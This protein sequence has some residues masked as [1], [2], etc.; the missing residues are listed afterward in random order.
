VRRAGS[1]ILRVPEPAGY[2][3]ETLA[4]AG[5]PVSN[6]LSRDGFE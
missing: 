6:G 2:S 3:S 1:P 4:W 5:G